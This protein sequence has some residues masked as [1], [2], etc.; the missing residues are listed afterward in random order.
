MRT[1]RAHNPTP[2]SVGTDH[3][4]PSQKD[5]EESRLPLR[6]ERMKP[7]RREQLEENQFLSADSVIVTPEETGT[8]K[9][10]TSTES[11]RTVA[12]CHINRYQGRPGGS[13]G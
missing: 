8:T 1:G 3:V 11:L 2:H 4:W 6:Y 10:V 13:V 12:D 5:S 9:P 7:D